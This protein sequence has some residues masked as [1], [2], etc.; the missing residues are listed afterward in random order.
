MLRL[1][2]C[3][4][5]ILVVFGRERESVKRHGLFH[6][7]DLKSLSHLVLPLPRHGGRVF[8]PDLGRYS[9]SCKWRFDQLTLAVDSGLILFATV[10][11]PLAAAWRLLIDILDTPL[12]RQ[13][14]DRLFA[15]C[16]VVLPDWRESCGAAGFAFCGG[17]NAFSSTRY[18]RRYRRS[19][20]QRCR[21]W[22]V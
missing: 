8:C 3:L 11:R 17:T 7:R 20:L 15:E 6:Q 4:D 10:F 5:R 21:L 9:C 13:I 2:T 19:R 1:Q 16:N 18:R 22:T 12:C 14:R